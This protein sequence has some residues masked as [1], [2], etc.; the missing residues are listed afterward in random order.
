MIDK[1][2]GKYNRLYYIFIFLITSKKYLKQNYSNVYGVCAIGISKIY[3]NDSKNNEIRDC[4]KLKIHI[5]PIEH[6]IK[7]S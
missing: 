5:C 7:D 3:D 2:A 4:N 1:H 6:L